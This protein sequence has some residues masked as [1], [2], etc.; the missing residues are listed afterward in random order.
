MARLKAKQEAEVDGI[1]LDCTQKLKECKHQLAINN[2]ETEAQ[3]ISLSDQLSVALKGKEKLQNEQVRTLKYYI[4]KTRLTAA[5]GLLYK[6][7]GR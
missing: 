1:L 5:A 4:I 6:D 3:I 7:Y 2:E